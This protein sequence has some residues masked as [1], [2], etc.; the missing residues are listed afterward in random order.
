MSLAQLPR[1][2]RA[3]LKAKLLLANLIQEPLDSV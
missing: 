3:L 2:H 1:H